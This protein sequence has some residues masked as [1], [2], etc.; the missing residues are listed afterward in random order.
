MGEQGWSSRPDYERAG[1]W[2][3]HEIK[4]WS[5]GLATK[6]YNMGFYHLEEARDYPN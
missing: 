5:F 4:W 6:S 3:S 2:D 1:K